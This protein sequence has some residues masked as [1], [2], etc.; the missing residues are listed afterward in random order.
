MKPNILHHEPAT[1][2]APVMRKPHLQLVPPPQVDNLYF[3][4]PKSKENFISSGCEILNCVL[5]GGWP[6]GRISNVVGDKS[7]G[8]TLLAIEA[9]ANFA[10][11]YPDDP[12]IYCETEAA[13]DDEYAGA[14]GI[15]MGKVGRDECETVEEL[16]DKL[17]D[18]V[19]L[20][21]KDRS[22]GLYI[23]DS[24]DAL[25]DKAEK[26][27][28]FGDNT[29]GG[30]KPKQMGQLF[31]RLVKPLERSNVHVMIVSQTRDAIGVTFGKKHTRSGG[32]ALD[33][34]ASQILWLAYKGQMKKTVSKIERTIGAEIK[35]RIEKNKVGLPFRECEFEILF[36][37]G[38]DDISSNLGFLKSAGQLGRVGI[39]ESGIA[40]YRKAFLTAPLEEKIDM[41]AKLATEVCDAW[42]D[43]ERSFLPKAGK[44]QT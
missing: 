20:T 17:E 7:T 2:V 40:A 16:F 35:A 36:G 18:F 31:R 39:S 25:S 30:T 8:K 29:Y 26:E 32:R 34:Y 33:F 11:Q 22:H 1:T 14:L 37:Y 15:D 28:A 6:L 13:F 10:V 41:R 12:T 44:Y 43:I 38:I 5:G 4:T 24:L 27:R 21:M 23:V 19:S 3:S 42:F 9:L